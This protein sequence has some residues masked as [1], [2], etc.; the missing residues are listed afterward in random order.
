[1]RVYLSS[2]IV[3]LALAQSAAAQEPNLDAV[4]R[5]WEKT[6]SELK[7]FACVIDRTSVD[8]ALGAK[9]DF[10]GYALFAKPAKKGEGNLS[11]LQL[12]KTTNQDV[13]EKFIFTGSEL[14]EYVSARKEVRVYKLPN[15]QQMGLP[16]DNALGFLFGMG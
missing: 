6:M 8:K 12:T 15:A 9:D 16:Q 7:N 1:M 10:S 5:G 14:Y 3:V 2:V 4:L 13:F 11:R